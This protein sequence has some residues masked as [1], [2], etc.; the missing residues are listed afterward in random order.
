MNT[1]MVEVSNELCGDWN[2]TILWQLLEFFMVQPRG[3]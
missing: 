2:H 3:R 1:A